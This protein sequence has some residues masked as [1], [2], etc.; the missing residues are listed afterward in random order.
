MILYVNG[1]GHSAAAMA[2]NEFVAAEDDPDLWY[3]GR[4][5]HP[6]NLQRSFGAYIASVLKARLL[7]EA[8]ANY[9]NQDIINQT[10]KF[11]ETNPVTEQVIAIIGMPAYD[12]TQFNEFGT[13]LKEQRVKHILYP[14]RDYVEWLTKRQHAPNEFGYFDQTAHKDWAG[15]LIKPLTQ[16]V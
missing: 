13:Y 3:M 15:N 2:S 10:K 7:V 14:S 1:D 8:D 4:A 5:P 16:I 6:A 12:Q 9:T 11:I